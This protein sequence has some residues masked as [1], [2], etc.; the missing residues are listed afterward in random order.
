MAAALLGWPD[1]RVR[2][3]ETDKTSAALPTIAE[4]PEG[5]A[6]F[7]AA[8]DGDWLYV[9]GGHT[10]E[11]HSYSTEEVSNAFRRVN[12]REGGAWEDLPTG[13]ALQGLALVSH[14]GYLYRIGGMVALNK[15]GDADDLRSLTD[16][17]RYDPRTRQ[18]T[19]IQP[20][21]EGRSSHGAVVVGGQLYV[22]GGWELR[23]SQGPRWHTTS[24]VL[25]LA[26]GQAEWKEL[27]K[28][29]FERRAL[30]AEAAG[31]KLLVTGGLIEGGISSRTDV[32]DLKSQAWSQGPEIPGTKMNAIGMAACALDGQIYVNGMD[33]DIYRLD[34]SAASWEAVGQ[35]Q[36][37][38]F[39]HHLFAL[40]PMTL[41]S[42]GGATR[43]G[44]VLAVDLAT[45]SAANPE[46]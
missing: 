25:D 11:T 21:P 35:L 14:G 38:R 40:R 19:S 43:T 46:R 41:L 36:P 39:H 5:I 13:P 31:G 44:K 8:I 26:A 24:L 34:P 20:L 32:F 29:P 42:V 28:Q 22:V 18:W 12:V 23:G 10:G 2:A 1:T 27:P 9:Y 37:A 4:L 30:A 17:S 45:L 15:P 3:A 33:G 16:V 6:S 7:G